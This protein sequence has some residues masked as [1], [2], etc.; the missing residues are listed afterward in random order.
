MTM[1]VEQRTALE[2]DAQ[3][4]INDASTRRLGHLEAITKQ[5][6]LVS[7]TERT[8]AACVLGKLITN[9]LCEERGNEVKKKWLAELSKQICGTYCDDR[10]LLGFVLLYHVSLRIPSLKTLGLSWAAKCVQAIGAKLDWKAVTDDMSSQQIERANEILPL[11]QEGVDGLGCNDKGNADRTA[12]VKI[13]KHY[14]ANGAIPAPEVKPEA[15]AEPEASEEQVQAVTAVPTL[16]AIATCL[17]SATTE[18]LIA[19]SGMLSL[20]ALERLYDALK[21]AINAKVAEYQAS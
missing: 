16:E 20:A 10:K 7:G 17:E 4:R 5:F 21:P 8:E 11:L 13:I 12:W 1:T 3:A 9:A 2:Q 19:I 14:I 15:S 6:S 18:N